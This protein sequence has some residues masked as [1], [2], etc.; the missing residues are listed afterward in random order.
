MAGEFL[1]NQRDPGRAEEALNS[2]LQAQPELVELRNG[3]RR[4]SM[5]QG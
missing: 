4:G 1:A 3:T 2:F 5:R